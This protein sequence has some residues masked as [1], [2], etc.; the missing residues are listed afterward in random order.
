MP[1]LRSASFYSAQTFVG[2]DRAMIGLFDES[3]RSQL[4][5]HVRRNHSMRIAAADLPQYAQFYSRYRRGG[6]RRNSEVTERWIANSI[7]KL[8]QSSPTASAKAFLSQILAPAGQKKAA[9]SR[10]WGQLGH[11]TEAALTCQPDAGK[12][13]TTG[14]GVAEKDNDLC[15]NDQKERDLAYGDLCLRLHPP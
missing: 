9:R 5:P 3:H 12:Q 1:T 11:Q 10:G 2:N 15:G 7:A 8:A 14:I 6:H 13:A 4:F